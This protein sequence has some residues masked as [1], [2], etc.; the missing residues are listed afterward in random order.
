MQAPQEHVQKAPVQGKVLI[1]YYSRTG[2]TERVARL[3]AK[4]TG[5]ELCPITESRS[6]RGPWGYVRS[7]WQSTT[8]RQPVI[9]R[10]A[11]DPTPADLVLIGTP[12]WGGQL[13]SPVRSFAHRHARQI[14]RVA[15][16]GTQ[17]RTGSTAAFGELRQILGRSPVAT[18]KLTD[19]E[20]DAG[21][22]PLQIKTFAR[23][24]M[25]RAVAD[26]ATPSENS[27]PSGPALYRQA[28]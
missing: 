27:P 3:L 28:A 19:A 23:R 17:R 24:V 6:R 13:A 21:N 20:I 22:A 12:I 15:F 14:R 8:G 7:A 18:L 1:V 4:A 26:S 2:Y 25:A 10:L 5:G 16:F 9:D 11:R